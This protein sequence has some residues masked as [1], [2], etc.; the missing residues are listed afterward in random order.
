MTEA[1]GNWLSWFLNMLLLHTVLLLL[2]S[3]KNKKEGTSSPNVEDADKEGK[4]H[5]GWEK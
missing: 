4:G 2:C 3:K 1:S 5:V